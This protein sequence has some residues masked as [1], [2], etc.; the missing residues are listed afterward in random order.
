L[1]LAAAFGLERRV[2]HDYGELPWREGQTAA[3][4]VKELSTALHMSW[5][6]FDGQWRR[7]R[8][9]LIERALSE[10]GDVIIVSHYVAINVLVGVALSD[11]RAVIIRPA[12]ASITEFHVRADGLKVVR[13]PEEIPALPDAHL[14]LTEGSSR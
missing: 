1:P 4:R 10:T 6:D 9:R 8:E 3:E 14:S 12:N 7:W 11:D 13:F 5:P 2:E